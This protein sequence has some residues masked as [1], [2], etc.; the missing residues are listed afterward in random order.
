[1][2]S[3][4]GQVSGNSFSTFLSSLITNGLVFI[5]PFGLFLMVINCGRNSVNMES[6]HGERRGGRL[7]SRK[8]VGAAQGSREFVGSLTRK[9]TRSSLD[10][11]L[12]TSVTAKYRALIRYKS[13][14]KKY[15][16]IYEPRTFL[17]IIPE[18][19]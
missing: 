18:E 7:G 1:M 5:A 17:R 13:A 3:P 15:A 6:C 19:Y 10:S 14:L 9:K 16:R 12:M 8:G 4:D 2:G 11:S